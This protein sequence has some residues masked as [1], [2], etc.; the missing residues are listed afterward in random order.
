MKTPSILLSIELG[1]ILQLTEARMEPIKNTIIGQTNISFLKKLL[2][3]SS[4]KQ[5]LIASNIANVSTPGY[6]PKDIDF[7]KE[8]SSV[9][10]LRKAPSA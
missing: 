2:D 9:S 1:L 8:L 3:L 5:K 7:K 10:L 4:Q 6:K